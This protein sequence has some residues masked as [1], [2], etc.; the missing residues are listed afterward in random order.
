MSDPKTINLTSPDGTALYARYWK[1]VS[2]ARAVICIVH[3]LGD[4]SGRYAELAGYLTSIDIAVYAIDLHGHGL[5]GGKRGHI[6]TYQA[7]LD[8]VEI[9]LKQARLTYLDL[10]MFLYG[11]SFGGGIVANY[12]QLH[13]SKELTGAILSSP[14]FRL[15]FEP[16]AWKLKLAQITQQI[17]PSLTL[18]NE[19]DSR[20]IS[21]EEEEMQRYE[22]DPLVHDRISARLFSLAFRNGLQALR[23]ESRITLPM[24]VIHGKEDQVTDY[25]ATMEFVKKYPDV[26]RVVLME[27]G[28]HELHH[29]TEKEKVMEEIG[30][31]LLN[32]ISVK[33]A[34]GVS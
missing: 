26:T 15:A 27:N 20:W 18:S 22:D 16:P 29:D 4:H 32:E 34:S 25:H 30:A 23:S 17:Y 12:L 33:I 1:P 31:F 11:H 5:S 14:W 3:G 2:P 21:K 8:D 24:L 9:L 13:S 10:P 28:R 19:L 7:L 6:H